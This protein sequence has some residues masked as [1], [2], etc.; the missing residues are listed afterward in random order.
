MFPQINVGRVLRRAGPALAWSFDYGIARRA[1]S[2]M[3]DAMFSSLTTLHQAIAQETKTKNIVD[4]GLAFSA[5]TRV[6][7]EGSKPRISERLEQLFAGL[8]RINEKT[9]YEKVHAD[10]CN[11]FAQNIRSAERKLKNGRIKASCECSYGQAAKVLD[12]SAKVYVYYCAQPSPETARRLVPML[13]GAVDVPIMQHLSSRFPRAGIRSKTI[14]QVGWDE[15]QC[16]QAL[17]AEEITQDFE[18]QIH[19]VQYDDIMWRR[20]NR[21]PQLRSAP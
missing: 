9:D 19:P 21:P 4:M 15:Y 17:L 5:M 10:F 11:W 12:I 6:F 7:S 2:D 20:L 14:E 8:D 1:E 3:Q 13:H 16:L 18:S